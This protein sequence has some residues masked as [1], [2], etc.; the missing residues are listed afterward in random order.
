MG[1]WKEQ[2]LLAALTGLA[3]LST[4]LEITSTLTTVFP[5]T[6][7]VTSSA[8]IPG[9]TVAASMNIACSDGYYNTYG[10][11]WKETCAA[12]YTSG[13]SNWAG[14]ALSLRAC[15]SACSVRSGCTAAAYDTSTR[16][17]YLLQGD[18]TVSPGGQYQ[19]VQRYAPNASPCVSTWLV[20]ETSIVTSTEEV[21]YTVT[22]SSTPSPS[23]AV[24]PSNTPVAPSSTPIA[25]SPS[26]R[27]SSSASSSPVSSPVRP[28]STPLI[29][30]SVISSVSAASP[31]VIPSGSSSLVFLT[32]SSSPGF[33][34][35]SSSLSSSS[36]APSPSSSLLSTSPSLSGSAA[37]SIAPSTTSLTPNGSSLSAKPS[38]ESSG[39]TPSASTYTVTTTQVQT[40]TSCAAVVT[41]CPAHQQTTYLTTETIT[42]V[43][44]VCPEKDQT[45]APQATGSVTTTP[46]ASVIQTT[47][48]S[49]AQSTEAAVPS[50]ISTS[51]I[52]VTE[53]DVVT[54]C[55]PSVHN[56]PAGQRSTYTTTKTVATYTTTYLVAAT[57][58][59]QV[60]QSTGTV[61]QTVAVPTLSPA[62]PHASS[63]G[64]SG[65]YNMPHGLPSSS[66]KAGVVSSSSTQPA[67]HAATMNSVSWKPTSSVTTSAPG[68]L[69]NGAHRMGHSS[70]LVTLVLVLSTLLFI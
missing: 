12:S 57:E 60:S 43:T 18:V 66:W 15:A 55:P 33:S 22:P 26:I 38:D 3:P 62:Q 58:S 27:V 65:N 41:N 70:T 7:V 16:I 36:S 61:E 47:G 10:A 13:T 4:A 11:V 45:K 8:D 32:A 20:T 14:T 46:H 53:I 2:L 56:C 51:T 24:T 5:T 17:C 28:S 59:A 34:L 29:R 69:F 48:A 50:Q 49:S 54:A 68:T 64:A 23:V 35:T 42:Y 44:T 63:Q 31:S 25:S 37:S 1:R 40:I 39:S 19:V 9:C 21:V 52:Y 30:T 67:K 6:A